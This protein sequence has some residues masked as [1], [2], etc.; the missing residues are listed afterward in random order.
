[1]DRVNTLIFIDANQYLDL[2]RSIEGKKL[3]GLLQEQ[4]DYIFVTKQVV[5]EV[6]RNKLQV[7]AEFLI[8]QFEQLKVRTIFLM[9]PG[10][11]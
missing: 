9:Y 2:Y 10:M 3:L 1:M 4:R 7:M 5:E 8:K 6:Q 11:I